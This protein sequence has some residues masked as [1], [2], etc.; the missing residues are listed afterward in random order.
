MMQQLRRFALSMAVFALAFGMAA[1]TFTLEPTNGTKTPLDEYVAKPDTTYKWNV[2]KTVPGDGCTTFIVDLVSQTW[3]KVPEVDKPVWQHWLIVV[4]P[5]VVKHDTGFL[6][7]GGG[8]NGGE[9]PTAAS[10]QTITMAKAT[11]S[12]VAELKMVPNQPLVLNGDGKPRTE[13]DLLAYGWA[14]FMETHDPT[15][16][17]RFAMVKS[18]VRGMDTITALMASDQGGK[19]PVNKFV[20]AGGSKRGWTTWLTGAVDKRVVAIMPLV[21]DI[22]NVKACSINHF[23]A[24]GFWAPAIGDYTAHGIQKSMDTPEHQELMRIEDPYFYRNRFTMPKFI[25]NA[26]GDQYFPPDSSKFYFDDLP[27]TKYLRY[28]PN[29]DHSLKD[30]DASDSILAFYHA[31]LTKAPL[32]KFTWK[33]ESDGAI[34]VQTET[35]PKEV[36]VWQA[37]NPKARD[38]RLMTIGKAYKKTT[39]E[40]VTEGT[41]VARVP[42]P[43]SGWTA[44][45]VELVYD[46]GTPT[47]YKFTTQV[48]IA[49]DVLPHTIEEFKKGTK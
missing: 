2:V 10:A 24:Y 27:G 12:V 49:P 9:P 26:G 40:P 47:P 13:D 45:F 43:E 19:Q 46:N 34:R 48:G 36:N 8:R 33:M 29:A 44:F 42:K 5:D 25:V 1:G 21:I 41:Y 39:L 32:P 7:I 37:T 6:M 30:S 35:K 23:C 17:P 28:V 20:V 11:N 18:A 14:K 15:W 16:I 4:K 38:F 22:V 31:I 3:R